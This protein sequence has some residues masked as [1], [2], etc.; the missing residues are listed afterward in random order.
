[1]EDEQELEDELDEESVP[2]TTDKE[3]LSVGE[4]FATAT[5]E[6]NIEKENSRLSMSS[7]KSAKEYETETEQTPSKRV[8]LGAVNN[9]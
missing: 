3:D 7:M 4:S 9:N 2:E 1:M 5:F 6:E 8:S